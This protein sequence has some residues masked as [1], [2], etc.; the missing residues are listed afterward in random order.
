MEIQEFKGNMIKNSDV[1]GT[2]IKNGNITSTTKEQNKMKI[3]ALW[4]N[5]IIK[6]IRVMDRN[7]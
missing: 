4:L 6:V 5:Q 3:H 1:S 2:K 7:F